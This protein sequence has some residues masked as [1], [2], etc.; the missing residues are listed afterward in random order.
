MRAAWAG[1][2]GLCQR[3]FQAACDDPESFGTSISCY[4]AYMRCSFG[5]LVCWESLAVAAQGIIEG[6]KREVILLGRRSNQERSRLF[7]SRNQ[8]SRHDVKLGIKLSQ[9]LL[10]EAR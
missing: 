7:S 8:L 9:D 10:A 3:R 2:S 4:Q 1:P 6:P 5:H